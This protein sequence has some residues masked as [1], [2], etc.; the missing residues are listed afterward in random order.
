MG[1][2]NRNIVDDNYNDAA[3]ALPNGAATT[4]S[5]DIDLGDIDFAG[6]NFELLV[7]VPAFPVGV[8]ANGATLTV[9]IVAGA[10]ASPTTVILGSVIVATGAGGAGSAAAEKPFRLPPDCPRYVRAQFVNSAGD[11]SAYDAVV[12]L[13][14]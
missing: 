7:S 14:F 9:N 4:Y 6:E 3:V 10:A 1:V 5:D 2:F 13:R 11:K 8:Q 12:G